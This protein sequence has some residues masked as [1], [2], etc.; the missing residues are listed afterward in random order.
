MNTWK[1]RTALLLLACVLLGGPGDRREAAAGDTPGA[2][3]LEGYEDATLVATDASPE[4]WRSQADYVCAGGE[5]PQELLIRIRKGGGRFRF[6]PG[7]YRVDGPGR[8]LMI[9][10]NTWLAGAYAIR[11]PGRLQDVLYPDAQT[12]A[13][14]RT[15][16]ELPSEQP[17][18]DSQFGLIGV[19]G[20]KKVVI[21]S[22]ALS[23]H[24]ILKLEHARSVEIRN[25]LIHNYRGSYPDGAWC[26]MGYGRATGSLWLTGKC[27]DITIRDTQIQFSSHHGFNLHSNSNKNVARNIRLSGVRALYCG[28]GMLR[29]ENESYWADAEKNM[30]KTQGYGYYDWSVAFDLC[31]AQ[32]VQGLLLED[33]YALEGWKAGFYTEPE[34]SGGPIKDLQLLRCRSDYA[35]RRAMLPGSKKRETII[36]EGECANFF[37]QGGYLEGCVSIGATKAGYLL[38]PNRP[39]ANAQGGGVLRMVNCG[40]YGSHIALVTEMYDSA[41]LHTQGF[42]SVNAGEQAL[43]LFGSGDFQLLDTVIAAPGMKDPPILIGYMLRTA[44]LGS[45]DLNNRAA[46]RKGGKYDVLRTDLASSR[47]TGTVYQLA[48]GVPTAEIKQGSAFNGAADPLSPDSG[49]AL[50]RDMEGA[51]GPEDFGVRGLE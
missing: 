30:P 47:I 31:E 5:L 15:T 42:W 46:N 35:G 4:P 7:E 1:R 16:A 44:F 21:D 24:A 48:D 8:H 11:Q 22:I 2:L 3:L 36:R 49:I 18:D 50:V 14:F 38:N 43:R 13:V 28:C 27:S 37:L 12:M 25:V 19:T 10:S 45:R 29:G 39:A 26:N 9:G 41:G 23:G 40:D 34:E 32:T 6:A 17:C 33:C 20:Q 51:P